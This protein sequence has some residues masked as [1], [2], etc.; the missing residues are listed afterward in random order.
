MV[1]KIEGQRPGQLPPS[2]IEGNKPIGAAQVGT[3]SDVKPAEKQIQAARARRPTRPMT[4]AERDH[5]F[6]LVREEADKMFGQDGLPHSKRSTVEGAVRMA[7]D[8]AIIKEDE[9]EKKK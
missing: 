9:T 8:S 6:Q 3:I 7:I 2:A 4:A 1:K 5:L